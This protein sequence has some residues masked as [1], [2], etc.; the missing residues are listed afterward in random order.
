MEYTHLFGVGTLAPLAGIIG[1]LAAGI[2][3]QIILKASS[4]TDKMKAIQ[5]L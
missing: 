5:E 2:L 1:L 3:Y 4:G